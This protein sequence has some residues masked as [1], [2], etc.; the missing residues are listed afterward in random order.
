MASEVGTSVL[1]RPLWF[2]LG[3]IWIVLPSPPVLAT[4]PSL[5]GINPFIL[6]SFVFMVIC[7]FYD[8]AVTED[9]S[10]GIPSEPIAVRWGTKPNDS[11]QHF[12]VLKSYS[13]IRNYVSI[14]ANNYLSIFMPML[15]L[16]IRLLIR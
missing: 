13:Q 4:F 8:K 16:F 9:Y 14:P 7:G 11:K 12:Q 15:T 1:C 5:H 3:G 6:I 10:I 2:C